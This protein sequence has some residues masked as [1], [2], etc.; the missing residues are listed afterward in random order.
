MPSMTISYNYILGETG[1][2]GGSGTTVSTSDTGTQAILLTIPVPASTTHQLNDVHIELAGLK[3]LIITTT[4]DCTI[5]TNDSTTPDDTI[6]LKAGKPWVW[7]KDAGI[8]QPLTGDAGV[9]DKLYST[10]AA[11][12]AITIKLRG[13]QDA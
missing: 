8:T 2:G 13:I 9:I 4:G 12:S 3:M 11:A 7:R 5:K 10:N 1:E 6:T